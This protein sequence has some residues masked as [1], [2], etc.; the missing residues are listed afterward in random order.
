MQPAPPPPTA[1]GPRALLTLSGDP[2]HSFIFDA[3]RS[4]LL[5]SVAFCVIK[6]NVKTV[7]LRQEFNLALCTGNLVPKSWCHFNSSEN[8]QFMKGGKQKW[9]TFNFWVSY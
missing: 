7:V 1:V 9:N 8:T 2:A 6:R 3:L 5:G 4:V